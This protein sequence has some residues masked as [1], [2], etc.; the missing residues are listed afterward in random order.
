LT[1]A[2]SPLRLVAQAPGRRGALLDPRRVP[3]RHRLQV[4]DCRVDLAQPGALHRLGEPA[5]R[6]PIGQGYLLGRPLGAIQVG[7]LLREASA[8]PA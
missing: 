5:L 6:A 8:E 7:Q 3:L 4:A 1:I 2:C